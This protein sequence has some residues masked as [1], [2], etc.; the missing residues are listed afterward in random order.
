MHML[1]QIFKLKKLDNLVPCYQTWERLK[2]RSRL[3]VGVDMSQCVIITF[4]VHYLCHNMILYFLNF[5][6]N[7]ML[8]QVLANGPSCV[9][10]SELNV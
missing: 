8:H 4:H 3:E 5:L 6:F 2:A 10:I 7:Q 1:D 9:M